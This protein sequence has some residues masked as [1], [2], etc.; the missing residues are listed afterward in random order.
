MARD[1]IPPPS[2]ARGPSQAELA[3]LFEKGTRI[4]PTQAEL[5]AAFEAA[6]P[7]ARVA[8]P[9]DEFKRAP[10]R[11][12]P[13]EAA[14]LGLPTPAEKRRL[15]PEEARALGLPMPPTGNPWD[16]FPRA[17]SVGRDLEPPPGWRGDPI[18]GQ[19]S[20]RSWRDDPIVRPGMGDLQA[21][22]ASHVGT[23]NVPVGALTGDPETDRRIA[24]NLA[25]TGTGKDITPRDVA[26]SAAI[27]ASAVI[28]NPVIAGALGGAGF[29]QGETVGDVAWDAAKGAAVAKA[30][31]LAA[32]F[33]R[34]IA[35]KVGGYAGGKLDTAAT[36]AGAAATKE[37]EKAIASARGSYGNA[38]ANE[39]RAIEVLLRAEATGSLSPTEAEQLAKLKASPEWAETIRNVA[40]NYMDDFGGLAST[41]TDAKAAFQTAAQGREQDIAA[42]TSDLLSGGEAK[43]QLMARLKRY[44]PMG[45]AGGIAGHVVGGPFGALL[46]G[47][48][49]AAV[50]PML[51]AVRRAYQSPAVQTAVW[52]PVQRAAAALEGPVS[53][54]V[55]RGATVSAL[56]PMGEWVD[57][58]FGRPARAL[59]AGQETAGRDLEPPPSARLSELVATKPE[60]FG[61]YAPLFREILE[62]R[63]ANAG[64]DL[65][66][67]HYALWQTDP[68]YRAQVGDV[69]APDPKA[70]ARL[71]SSIDPNVAAYVQRRAA[72][73]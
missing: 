70:T 56:R 27:A 21:S 25:A 61:P 22:P 29:S 65:A 15:S 6:G 40:R 20:G 64:T 69:L 16:E 67:K 36:K 59:A 52:S 17:T 3:A 11:L 5:A 43:A 57:E 49:G 44:G 54:A 14:T 37:I 47:A 23:G 42:R 18:V 71:K 31:P 51:H 62:Q 19:G 63:G 72:G 33:G 53:P 10:K 55:A 39:S 34:F 60:T 24:E 1:L 66:A 48:S 7:S 4:P 58:Q 8:N 68:A 9:W 12:S 2:A 26:S 35:S 38:R 32:Q 28:P 41:T 45:I 50:R 13:E 30:L 46:G 73:R